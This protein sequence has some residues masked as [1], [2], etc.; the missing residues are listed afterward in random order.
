MV[1]SGAAGSALTAVRFPYSVMS[2]ATVSLSPY[3]SSHLP[4]ALEVA[5]NQLVPGSPIS[6]ATATSLRLAA[7][8]AMSSSPAQYVPEIEKSSSYTGS[9][10]LKHVLKGKTQCLNVIRIF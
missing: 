4:A 5:S 1:F 10:L 2:V 6:P 3:S 8:A 9:P 7:A